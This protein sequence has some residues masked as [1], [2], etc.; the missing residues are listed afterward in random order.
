[1]WVRIHISN[2]LRATIGNETQL[3]S[4]HEVSPCVSYSAKVTDL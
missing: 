3:V 1:M 2:P 4:R